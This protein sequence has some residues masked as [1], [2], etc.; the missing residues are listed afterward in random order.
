MKKN[1]GKF[2]ICIIIAVLLILG[3]SYLFRLTKE[4]NDNFK[5]LKKGNCVEVELIELPTGNYNSST[6]KY[7]W[8]YSYV[9]EN[10][11]TVLSS[12]SG[13]YTKDEL[14]LIDYKMN[15]YFVGN[16][17]MEE[18]Y[19]FGGNEAS[20]SG[21]I[22]FYSLSLLPILYMVWL[23]V[24]KK[25]ETEVLKKGEIVYAEF[26]GAF[27]EGGYYKIKFC[28]EYNGKKVTKRSRAIYPYSAAE[29]FKT[30]GMI[31]IKV[32]KNIAVISQRILGIRQ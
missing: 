8:K 31:E 4:T 18:P 9:D 25:I 2:V 17:S 7:L 5:S 10:G 19:L 22:S 27:R 20:Y 14:A 6:T 26:L 28:Y 11:N 15:V 1:T 16:K 12:T 13:R 29:A 23:I 30:N 21:V 32:Y 24:R 3:G